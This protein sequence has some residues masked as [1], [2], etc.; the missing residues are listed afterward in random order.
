MI[1]DKFYPKLSSIVSTDALPDA[2]GF[3]DNGIENLLEDIYIR[4]LQF[5]KS[6][7][8]DSRTY[9]L[10]LLVYKRLGVEIPGTGIWI[11]LNPPHAS[12][13]DP[14]SSEVHV[15][16]NVQWEIMKYFKQFST[17]NFSFDGKGFFNL[18]LKV[19]DL[20]EEET[21]DHAIQSYTPNDTVLEFVSDV[22]SYYAL[23][24]PNLLPNPISSVRA[25]AIEETVIN[26]DTNPA[27]T[28]LQKGAFEVIYDLYLEDT[29]NDE[30]T[31]SRLSGMF[32]LWMGPSPL[33]RIKSMIRPKVS[34]SLQ[35]GLGV[36]FPRDVLLPVLPNDT[37][38][39]DDNIKYTLLFDIG[40]FNFSS[41]SGIGYDQTLTATFPPSHPKAQIGQTGLRFQI[42]NAK[43]DLSRTKNI[44][45]ATADG[46][47]E[48]FVGV[49]VEQAAIEFPQFWQQ[50]T[51]APASTAAIVGRNLLIGTGGLSGT[52]GLEA[53]NNADLFHT[54]LGSQNGFSISLSSCDISFS[55]NA[56]VGSSIEGKLT[57]PRFEDAAN[58]GQ[59]AVIDVVAHIGNDSFEVTASSAQGLKI[60]I[61]GVMDFTI[62][63]LSV[64]RAPD[65]GNPGNYKFHISIGGKLEF[66][67]LA[68]GGSAPFLP[69]AIDVK[70]LTIYDDGS[71]EFVGGVSI[72]PKSL[73]LK[74]GPA[75]LSITAIH[76]GSHEQNGRKYLFFGFD[77]GVSMNPGGVDARG[78]GIKFYFSVDNQPLHVFFRI[79]GFGID[80]MIPGNATAQTAAVLISGYLSM[81]DP[82][83]NP[84]AANDPREGAPDIEYMGGVTFSIPKAKIAGS[85]G[86]RMRPKTPAW[87]IDI[88]LELPVP[89]PLGPTGLGIYG[90]RGLIG[91]H[92]VPTKQSANP[93]FTDNNTWWEYYKEKTP[94][95]L[96]EGINVAKFDGDQDGFALG[97]GLSLATSGDSGKIFSSKLFFLLGLPDVFL[98][99]GQA[100]IL[101]ERIG[102]DTTQDPPF[103]ALIAITNSSVEANFGVNYR[104]PDP[105]GK[106]LRLNALLEMGFFFNNGSAWYVN[107]GRDQPASKRVQARILD[108]F[109]GYSYLML[110]STGIKAGSGT[111]W[112]FDKKFGPVKLSLGASIDVGGEISWG[113]PRQPLP[114]PKP[115]IGGFALLAGYA[116]ISVF[117]FKLG[118]SIAASL[119]AEAPKPF[120][121][122]GKFTLTINL[123][124]P[125]KDINLSVKLEWVFNNNVDLSEI[126]FVNV[127][128]MAS[129]PSAQAL[130]MMSKEPYKL[131]YLP[132][133]NTSSS[134]I[135]LP[136]SSAWN[137]AFENYVIPM[138]SRVDIEF[139]KPVKPYTTRFGGVTTS[140]Q[141]SELNP[142]KKGKS[143]QVRHEYIVENIVI[144]SYDPNGNVWQDYN[145][146]T[147][148]TPSQSIAS[149]PANILNTAD[150]GFWQLSEPGKFTK[151]MIL[152]QTQLEYMTQ[153]SPQVV[154]PEQF[155][156]GGASIF[157]EAE[158][159]QKTCIDFTREPSNS[160]IP[161]GQLH[162]EGDA[163]YQINGNDGTIYGALLTSYGPMNGLEIDG[164]STLEVFFPDPVACLDLLV[165]TG[166]PSVDIR[167][168]QKQ[169]IG[170][171]SG[172]P[173]YQFVLVHTNTI[174]FTTQFGQIHYEDAALPIDKVEIVP[175]ACSGSNANT[176]LTYWQELLT[177]LAQQE[178]LLSMSCSNATNTHQLAQQAY[179]DAVNNNW[180]NQP[181]LATAAAQA[182]AQMNEICDEYIR[183]KN[184]NTLYTTPANAGGTPDIDGC[185]TLLHRACWLDLESYQTNINIPSQAAVT[186][187]NIA[188]VQS[189]QQIVQPIWRPNT[190][191]AIQIE[192]KDKVYKG[193]NYQTDY[194]RYYTYGFRTA[195]PPG[196]F[197]KWSSGGSGPYEDAAYT[198]LASQ[199]REEEYKLAGL[200]HYIDYKK[201]FPNADGAL[202]NAKPI[203]FEQA[204]INVFFKYQYVYSMYSIWDPYNGN[205]DEQS[206]LELQIKDPRE[207]PGGNV[208]AN[209]PGTM[210]WV[211]NTSVPTPGAVTILN[212]F[213]MNGMNCS[214]VI[215]PIIPPGMNGAYAPN[216]LLPS[217]IYQA[218]WKANFN[219]DAEEVH[220]Y[221]FQTSRYPDFKSQVE[222]HLLHDDGQGGLEKAI[223]TMEFELPVAEMALITGVLANSSGG[224]Y[225][226]LRSTFMHHYDRIVDG[227]LKAGA[228]EDPVG[229][230]FLV[231]ANT[232]PGGSR[233]IFGVL[234]RNPEPFNDPKL[235]DP[236]VMDTV[237]PVIAG[238]PIAGYT[239]VHSKDLSRA[240]ILHNA[241][242]I[243]AGNL[244]IR[245]RYYEYDGAT[246]VIPVPSLDDITITIN[247]Q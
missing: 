97:A 202:I 212:N 36:E 70:R 211:P 142:P 11:R 61:P 235:P 102:L 190:I 53:T 55:Q 96:S 74:L 93:S 4:D 199:N 48:D 191:Y 181:A 90:F 126:M 124:W 72:L 103:S 166:S 127:L 79:N 6:P 21:L 247:L 116:Q 195:G 238:N 86:M 117:K 9:D 133:G 113:A 228:L 49:F 2:L 77:G 163:S 197:H 240:L 81:R 200:K 131:N 177:Y 149:V 26:V 119:A 245:F 132:I 51:G 156:F 25:D 32:S 231:L 75:E 150:Y 1:S 241:Q 64:G 8:G 65:P 99:Q 94:P 43:L 108:L 193:S 122:T 38:D 154:I 179:D 128:D 134:T 167:Y 180:P 44:A 106:I 56:I 76:F 71:I 140:F 60:M 139:T 40:D 84:A 164:M 189:L 219:G 153:G 87:L 47:P 215:G 223:F 151:L 229:T 237:L 130:N 104:I 35:L 29:G 16:V 91:Q 10:I 34:A 18:I 109:N 206:H 14:N 143:P 146:Y 145:I 147:A 225:D 183:I 194:S 186:G 68:P 192:T 107:F 165:T 176:Y 213:M 67:A 170:G 12:D 112:S 239:V 85:A 236:P 243:P 208:V 226:T 233:T 234:V 121:V 217:K 152:A 125:F 136:G 178:T 172:A 207:F 161:E 220:K 129:A 19:L 28:L 160:I 41:E 73:S 80:L 138:D 59:P 168:Y 123:P 242:N 218:I 100:A 39:P 37:V 162:F 114:K 23:S 184:L 45:E 198:A 148:N 115:Q 88:G 224:N 227:I 66:T 27:L 188:M 52:I 244:D 230:E 246:Y 185:V 31:L 222:S 5:V 158:S 169:V 144:K 171:G 62:N 205:A 89:I 210:T 118:F 182:L 57:I 82:V 54:R 232:P 50:D 141:N 83:P 30:N 201:S 159:I 173:Q 95:P 46:R 58:P 120:I 214:G 137:G 216:Y 157:C 111:S 110:S 69:G 15:S 101:S 24:G 92:Y 63:S 22:N 135:P 42:A 20:Y 3:I 7:D 203:F 204:R 155:G 196:H 175:V 174:T 221:N 105:S 13:P 187:Q 209:Q 98:L 78:D 17:S 33:E